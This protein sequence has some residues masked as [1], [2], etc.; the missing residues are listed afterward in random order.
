MRLRDP[1]IL[2][3]ALAALAVV[4]ASGA[5]AIR[6]FLDRHWRRPLAPQGPPPARFSP[7]EAS[8]QPEACGTCHLVQLADWKS[9]LHAA[10]MAPGVA[11]QLVE[12]LES[13]PPSALSCFTCHAPLA[14]QAPRVDD[15][16]RARTNPAY[17]AALGARGLVCAGCHVRAHQRFGPPRRDGSLAPRAPSET[18]PH[19]GVT[20]APAFLRSE[21]CQ[22]CH[23]F[24]A[25]GFALNGKLLQATYDEWKASRFAREG[26]QCQDCHM[27]DRRH[28]WR[29]IHDADMVRSG[30]TIT[31]KAG[32][33]RYRPGELALV[34]LRVSSTRIGHAFPTY[35]TPRVVLSAELVDTAGQ[36]VAGSRREQV[37]GREVALDLS[38]ELADTRLMPGKSATFTYRMKIDARGVRARVS[39]VVEPDAFYV[40]FF[41]TLL[42]QGAGRGEAQIRQAL[43]AARRSPFTLFE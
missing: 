31:A 1:A 8:L 18:L 6:E 25:D 23:Q 30:L 10:S 26:V 2:I 36:V 17:D 29:G 19:N 37:I 4:N 41:D 28:R 11:G 15:G 42:R 22:S 39:V 9:S 38:R 16:G 7:L 34:T 43:E 3:A 40:A 14:E 33:A 21:F 5:D 27:P 24:T 35:V 12:M 32:A 13:D 20:R